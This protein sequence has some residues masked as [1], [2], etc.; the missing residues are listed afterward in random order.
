MSSRGKARAA[1]RTTPLDAEPCRSFDGLSEGG[2]ENRLP[3][4][5]ALAGDHP[6]P[7]YR[8]DKARYNVER[9]TPSVLA[10]SLGLTPASISFLA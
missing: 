2:S 5:G 7:D 8:E 6:E 1:G 3:P 9:P 10:T 4:A